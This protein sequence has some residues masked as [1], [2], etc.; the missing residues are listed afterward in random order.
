MG[1]IDSYKRLEKMCSCCIFHYYYPVFNYKPGIF[2]LI[3]KDKIKG[4][5]MNSANGLIP[6]AALNRTAYAA[7][8]ILQK[9]GS[10]ESYFKS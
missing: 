7:G 5:F 2:I 3:E 8:K 10:Y 9:G 6:D 4:F 1:F